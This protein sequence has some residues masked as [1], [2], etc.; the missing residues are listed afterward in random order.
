MNLRLNRAIC[1]Y[2]SRDRTVRTRELEEALLLFF[3]ASD[4]V[5]RP[6][7]SLEP[8]LLQFLSAG[9]ALSKCAFAY[10]GKRFVH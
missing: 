2:Q 3:L 7:H 8:F 1:K 4:A 9:S 6:G 10:P 5:A